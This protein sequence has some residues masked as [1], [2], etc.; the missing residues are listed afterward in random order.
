MLQLVMANNEMC[1]NAT[2]LPHSGG[3]V[4]ERPLISAVSSPIVSP[5]REGKEVRPPHEGGKDP[6]RLA[7]V[8]NRYKRAGKRPSAPHE[9]GNVPVAQ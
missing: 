7:R 8:R 9:A 5:S 2:A 4:P 3:R 6:V 1:W